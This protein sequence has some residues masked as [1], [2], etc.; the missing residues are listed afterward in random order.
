MKPTRKPLPD[1]PPRLRTEFRVSGWGVV[2]GL[3][4]F[5]NPVRACSVPVFRYAL[6]R[7]Q[8]DPY[9][10]ILE[11]PG[12]ARQPE[13]ALPSRWQGI[14]DQCGTVNLRLQRGSVPLD[15]PLES[16]RTADGPHG[17]LRFPLASG[18]PE[19]A[20]AGALNETRLEQMLDSPLRREIARRL[21]AGESAVWVLLESGNA[22]EDDRAA[23]LLG[24]RLNWLEQNLAIETLDPADLAAG[25]VSVPE[26]GLR[27]AFS[28]V[29]LSRSDEAEWALVSML[30]GTEA[31]LKDFP[32]PIAFPVF[33]RGRVLHA[34]VGR[35]ITEPN[36]DRACAFL[37]G[38]CSC[39]AKELNPGVDLLMTVDW[40][41]G[42][43]RSLI[44]S[45]QLPPLEGLASFEADPIPAISAAESRS[46][47]GPPDLDKAPAPDP[48]TGT[49]D[50]VTGRI[51]STGSLT[52]PAAPRPEDNGI[53]TAPSSTGLGPVLGGVGLMALLV[54]SAGTWLLWRRG[55]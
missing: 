36:I 55:R 40:D 30:L 32:D 10:L 46:V 15:N 26:A 8:A 18:I 43:A 44:R 35:G 27:V 6:E 42:I 47:P 13:A 39:Q 45:R 50:S 17:R 34:L 20:W 33:G 51:E 2:M 14:V 52:S 48:R 21:L 54:L 37:V 7:W 11:E 19:P 28:L 41:A 12:S 22:P 24:T 3:F 4:L 9:A 38:P 53:G 5:A 29:R 16:G 49:I 1:G 23:D 31:D 25:W